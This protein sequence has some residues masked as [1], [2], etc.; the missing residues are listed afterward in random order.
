[1]IR[2]LDPKLHNTWILECLH[3][4][5]QY[6]NVTMFILWKDIDFVTDQS[7]TSLT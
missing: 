2:I 4:I 5:S 3:S 1:M 7:T 6:V